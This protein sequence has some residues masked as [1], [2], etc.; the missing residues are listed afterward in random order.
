MS[1]WADAISTAGETVRRRVTDLLFASSPQF[2]G[3]DQPAPQLEGLFSTH[4]LDEF[5][6]FMRLAEDT[7][8]HTCYV[9]GKVRD[10]YGMGGICGETDKG[11]I[12][13]E[14]LPH[15]QHT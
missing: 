12:G 5:S 14:I 9:F 3:S 13:S 10:Q 2:S 1:I 6:G 8:S 15:T 4:V 11:H 7:S